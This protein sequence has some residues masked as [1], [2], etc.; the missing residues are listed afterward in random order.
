MTWAPSET[1]KAVY[2][3]L[4]ADPTLTTLLGGV[5]RVFDHVPDNT[6]YPY[7][8]I[9]MFPFNDRGSYTTEG[10]TVEF[11]ISAWVRGASRGSLA[12]QSIQKRIDE[13][14]HKANLSITGW[15][16]ITLRRELID[17]R[18]EDDNVTKQGIQR[19][20]LLLGEVTT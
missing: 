7:V 5:G 12:V 18:T 19:F 6:A 3:V 1:Q 4:S 10:V 16:I 17:E 9:S 20:R 2:A 15:K 11:Q 13:L 8:T 14:I